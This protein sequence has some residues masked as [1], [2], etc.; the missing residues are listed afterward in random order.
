LAVRKTL[1]KK[2]GKYSDG[3]GLWLQVSAPD[4]AS[5]VFR[6]SN[7]MTLS[8][9]G[10]PMSREMGLGSFPAVDL[11]EARDLAAAARKALASGGDPLKEREAAVA[12]RR[13]E[14]AKA[15]TFKAATEQFIAAH[16]AGPTPW[17]EIH[18]AQV[19]SNF[20]N[21]VF[22]V[23]GDL[24]VGAIDK[25]HIIKV[26]DPVWGE[27]NKT[28]RRIRQKIESVLDY[29]AARGLRA[30]GLNPARFKG[31][32]D[33]AFAQGTPKVKNYA[34]LDWKH[35]PAFMAALAQQPGEAARALRFTILTAARTGET[36]GATWDEIDLA[37]AMWTVPAERMKVRREH[38]VPLSALAV[39]LLEEIGPSSGYVF[40]GARERDPLSNM[41]ML[42][43]L[44]RMNRSDITPH[45]FRSA[46]RDWAAEETDTD[47]YVVEK[48]LAHTIPSKVEA[49][50][51]RG[52]LIKKRQHL[53]TAWDR[54]C[55]GE[56]L[57]VNIVPLRQEAA[58][59]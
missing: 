36:I 3:N 30:E 47:P 6:Y 11:D 28:A 56:S 57:A 1:I 34:A 52:D 16:K 40:K 20:E 27:R 31:N 17:S 51:R 48:A 35:V 2:P 19:Q 53:M 22:P 23:I 49:S 43:L 24:A 45:G 10:K 13:A 21:H 55:R 59:A 12:S 5:W 42:V 38:R 39:A 32:I 15:I 46:F 29:A 8:K 50:Y 4:R 9:N 54:F 14:V 58:A 26:L 25:A 7:A 18:A 33:A 37:A 44:R 41:A